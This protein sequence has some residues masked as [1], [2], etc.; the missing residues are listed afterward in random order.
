MYQTSSG[1]LSVFSLII[2]HSFSTIQNCLD[3]C[4]FIS[5]PIRYCI[6]SNFAVTFQNCVGC[7]SFVL[8]H[9]ELSETQ[10]LK[11]LIYYFKVSL[12]RKY[13]QSMT[14]FSSQSPR[15]EIKG[16]AETVFSPGAQRLL[17]NS[18][19]FLEEFLLCGYGAE[20]VFLLAV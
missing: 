13:E 20:P 12:G 5:V 17:L 8:L 7:I 4:G 6:F 16:S 19:S 18:F 9:D 3:D 15:A 11:I 1:L 10:W 14:G 2:L